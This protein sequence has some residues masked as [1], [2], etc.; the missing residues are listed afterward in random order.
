[1][2]RETL[3]SPLAQSPHQGVAGEEGTCTVFPGRV[4]SLNSV[5]AEIRPQPRRSL[6]IAGAVEVSPMLAGTRLRCSQ[7][8]PLEG[9]LITPMGGPFIQAFLGEP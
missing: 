2:R 6:V 3:I 8:Q 9:P 7:S 4:L 5:R 1:M